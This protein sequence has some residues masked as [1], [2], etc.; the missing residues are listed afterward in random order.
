M[1][2]AVHWHALMFRFVMQNEHGP[3]RPLGQDSLADQLPHTHQHCSSI[4]THVHVIKGNEF[5]MFLLAPIL[6]C[7]HEACWGFCANVAVA[8]IGGYRA[9]LV[10]GQSL[11]M[12]GVMCG[13]GHHSRACLPCQSQLFGFQL[14]TLESFLGILNLIEC[15]QTQSCL[16][17]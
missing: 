13:R 17:C 16:R 8:Y 12:S 4:H 10:V 2:C 3:E 6:A 15:L 1:L 14:A 9:V 7:L 5:L 11:H